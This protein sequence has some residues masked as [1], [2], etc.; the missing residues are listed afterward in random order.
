MSK[1]NEKLEQSAPQANAAHLRPRAVGRAASAQATWH[2]P[3][4]PA[5]VEPLGASL[6]AR[7]VLA[8]LQGSRRWLGWSL[9]G[10]MCILLLVQVS[11]LTT[12]T[13]ATYDL[14]AARTRLQRERRDLVLQL[15]TAQ[16]L[17]DLAL[18]ATAAGLQP[19]GPDQWT[20]LSAATPETRP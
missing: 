13:Y 11:V 3:Q 18:T 6:Q 12:R 16:P 19:A 15:S 9:V 1:P 2:A 20:V 10:L 14:E 8:L 4:P 7:R 17:A 5:A